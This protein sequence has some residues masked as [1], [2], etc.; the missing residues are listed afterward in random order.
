M[1]ALSHVSD[2]TIRAILSALCSDD[3]VRAKALGY[4]DVLEPGAKVKARSIGMS[5]PN[6]KKRKRTPALSIY[7]QC[8]E[9][10]TKTV[11]KSADI[12]PVSCSICLFRLM[13]TQP[14]HPKFRRHGAR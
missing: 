2:S 10:S 8:D 3:R 14:A 9:P 7:V 1:D 12:T 11:K 6:I 4:L 5:Q 13:V